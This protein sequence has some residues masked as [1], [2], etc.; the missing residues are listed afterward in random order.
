MI[1]SVRQISDPMPVWSDILYF[2]SDDTREIKKD[3][4]FLGIFDGKEMAG[5]FLINTWNSFCY[6]IHGGVSRDY[7][8]KGVDICLALG[9]FLFDYTP[10]VKI[11]APIPEY[12]RP[13]ASCLKKCGLVEEGRITKAFIKRYRFHDII[14]YGIKKSE[15]GR[16]WHQ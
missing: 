15:R 13:M 16:A 9:N 1:F 6:E 5:A 14:M 8:G 7:W 10:C 3:G 4:F 2:I 11:V 12:N